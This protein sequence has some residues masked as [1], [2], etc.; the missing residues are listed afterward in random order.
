MYTTQYGCI[1]AIDV[2]P[3]LDKAVMSEATILCVFFNTNYTVLYVG[4]FKKPT[5]HIANQFPIHNNFHL[6]QEYFYLKSL[7]T[8]PLNFELIAWTKCELFQWKVL[9]TRIGEKGYENWL[10]RLRA[11][12]LRVKLGQGYSR[13]EWWVQVFRA[14]TIRTRTRKIIL[15]KCKKWPD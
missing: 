5:Q 4:C 1:I 6:H 15:R 13:A 9:I 14:T 12:T 3:S 8:T 10:I 7:I 2:C 11:G